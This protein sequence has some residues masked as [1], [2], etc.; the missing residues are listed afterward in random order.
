MRAA[1]HAPRNPRRVLER[2]RGLAEIVERGVVVFADGRGVNPP[3]GAFLVINE[4]YAPV[5]SVLFVTAAAALQGGSLLVAAYYLDQELTNR[6]DEIDQIPFDEEVKKA[7]EDAKVR[8]EALRKNTGS[9]RRRLRHR[10]RR[11]RPASPQTCETSIPETP[12]RPRSTS[13]IRKGNK[14]VGKE[15]CLI[16][17]ILLTAS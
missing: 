17:S 10:H 2:R 7:D 6:K 14:I 1:E 16:P 8:S 15:S 9:L 3:G 12:G 4:S 13:I 11:R 5:C